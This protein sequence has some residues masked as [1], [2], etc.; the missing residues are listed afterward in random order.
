M[1]L[2]VFIFAY[3]R[4]CTSE[5]EGIFS[6]TYLTIGGFVEFSIQMPRVGYRCTRCLNEKNGLHH[7]LTSQNYFQM[8]YIFTKKTY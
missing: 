5:P 7:Q 3:M 8:H 1:C 4:M 6:F 2:C